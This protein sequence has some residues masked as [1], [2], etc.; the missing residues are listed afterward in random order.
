MEVFQKGESYLWNED[1][2]DFF[3]EHLMVILRE[4]DHY[5]YAKTQTRLSHILPSDALAL[6]RHPIPTWQFRPLYKES[7]TI[8]ADPLPADCY[9]K[10]PYL[11]DLI[12]ASRTPD[13]TANIVL[14]EAEICEVLRKHPHP[15]IAPYLGCTVDGEGRISGLC[16]PRYVRTLRDAVEVDQLPLDRE[17]CVTQIERGIQ[18][19]HRLGFVHNDINPG[20]IMFDADGTVVIIDF[21]SCQKV[22]EKLGLKR[23]TAGWMPGEE[24]DFLAWRMEQKGAMSE[25]SNDF[26][27]LDQIREYLLRHASKPPTQD[28]TKPLRE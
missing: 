2:G 5:F 16:F 13:D 7:L 1:K 9:V 17:S 20:N 12:P 23:A 4:N 27:E 11:T 24:L 3:F 6:D 28:D 14:H 25:Y 8:A 18:H 19:L 10:H 26:K 22:N 15:N 21:D